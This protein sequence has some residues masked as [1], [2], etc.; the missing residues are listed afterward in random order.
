MKAKAMS[1]SGNLGVLLRGERD[2]LVAAVER[3]ETQK[4]LHS[5]LIIVMGAGL[6]GA[7]MGWWRAPLQALYVSIKFPLIMLLTAIGN[8][9]LNAMLAPLLGLNMGLRQSFQ[10]VLLSF[11]IAA[12][13]LGSLSPLLAFFTWNAPPMGQAGSTYSFIMLLHVVA[14]A[15]AGIAGNW[16]LLQL[17]QHVSGNRS[18]AQ[19]VFLA[20]LAGNFFLG[21]QLSWILRPFIGSPGLDVDF[22]RK[23]AL[24]GNFY[25]TVFHSFL[26][27][28]NIK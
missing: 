16:R 22:L 2:F 23:T 8:S 11:S 15:F 20:W 14:I 26:N 21:S 28:L 25:E 12:A 27:V 3:P 4:L 1:L 24:Q 10:A 7:A 13:I 9:L 5:V 19:R 6:Y 17:L 18:V